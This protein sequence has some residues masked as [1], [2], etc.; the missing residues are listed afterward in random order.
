MNIFVT[1][2][3]GFLG[4][5]LITRLVG[6]GH[7]VT[8]LARSLEA[9]DSIKKAGGTPLIG[10]FTNISEWEQALQKY[11]V[12][13]HA[14]APVAF[15]GVW[16]DFERDIV[17]AT[18]DL[19]EASARN[20]VQRFVYIS[21]E[22]VLQDR[23][24][25]LDITESEPYPK[26][27]NSMY[28]KA[29]KLAEQALLRSEGITDCVILRPTFLWGKGVPALET[30]VKR[31]K[32]GTFLWIDGGKTVIECAH[33]DNIVEAILCAF[34]KGRHKGIYNITDD[35]AKTAREFIS[36][37]AATQGVTPPDKSMPGSLAGIAVWLV[38]AVWK[39]LGMKTVPPLTRFEL[40]FVN[41]PRRYNIRAA[42]EELGY[43]PRVSFMQGL[44][45]M[46]Q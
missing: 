2:G 26:E 8:G 1:G 20:K 39:L 40:A 18:S 46:S 5:R 17:K 38:E 23:K 34:S 14:A 44:E 45:E 36:A 13:V 15:W 31:M 16:S 29:K 28:G 12:V 6:E 30:I 21:S 42:K 37:L 19:Y 7:T 3:S 24:P 41:M 9:A 4:Q 33:V 10:E 35:E 25:L 11:E 22:A 43:S 32:A 27:P